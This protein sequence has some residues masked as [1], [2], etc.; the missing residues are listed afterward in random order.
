M[1]DFE[2]TVS[3]LKVILESL[4]REVSDRITRFAPQDLNDQ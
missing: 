2:S 4:N 1:A 3:L